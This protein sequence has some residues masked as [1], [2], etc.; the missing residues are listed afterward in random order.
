[1][2]QRQTIR[3]T[4]RGGMIMDIEDIPS[5]VDVLVHDYDID[6]D[7]EGDAIVDTTD[8]RAFEQVW[9][10]DLSPSPQPPRGVD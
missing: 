10:T 8:G 4:V 9:S 5:G 2:T 6:G 3:I 1:M 7:P